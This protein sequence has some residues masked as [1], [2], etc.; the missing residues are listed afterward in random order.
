[1]PTEQD[2]NQFVRC[3]EYLGPELT[4]STLADRLTENQFQ[5]VLTNLVQGTKAIRRQR[6]QAKIDGLQTE[7]NRLQGDLAP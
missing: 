5:G 2:L 4:A 6:A 1:M 3:N 7:I